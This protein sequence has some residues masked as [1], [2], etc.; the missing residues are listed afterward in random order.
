MTYN[1][2]HDLHPTNWPPTMNHLTSSIPFFPW[3]TLPQ[4]L[5]SLL[6]M[7]FNKHAPASEPLHL[8]F[9]LNTLLCIFTSFGS[10]LNCH[11]TAL[12]ET[13]QAV[14]SPSTPYSFYSVLFFSPLQLSLSNILYIDE[15]HCFLVS[16]FF[17][18]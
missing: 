3:F 11:L 4:P 18:Y 7:K 15:F 14:P 2:L 9:P 13:A 16:L 10:L 1:V 6:F 12:Y 8:L 17:F 5:A